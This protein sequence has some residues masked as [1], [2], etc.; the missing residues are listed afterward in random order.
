MIL[1]LTSGL[2]V[3][4]SANSLTIVFPVDGWIL[5]RINQSMKSLKANSSLKPAEV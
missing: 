5:S 2:R 3:D 1:S 4:F